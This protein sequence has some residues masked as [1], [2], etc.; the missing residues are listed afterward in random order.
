MKIGD[1]NTKFFLW[2]AAGHRARNEIKGL[3]ND[4]EVL[5]DKKY[6]MEGIMVQYFSELFQ[7]FNPSSEH[8]NRVLD[9][10][11]SKLPQRRSDFLALSFSAMKVQKAVFH[12]LPTKASGIDSMLALIYQNVGLPLRP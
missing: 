3:I 10:P 6:D 4:N 1:H 5:C 2:K 11:F 7:L 12:M 8:W 9:S